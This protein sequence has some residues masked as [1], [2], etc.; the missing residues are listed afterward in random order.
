MNVFLALRWK[1]MLKFYY[2]YT[3]YCRL[4]KMTESG[5]ISRIWK[6]W[7][8]DAK[9][10]C[11]DQGASGLGLVNLFTAWLILAGLAILALCIALIEYYVWKKWGHKEEVKKADDEEQNLKDSWLSNNSS[12]LLKKNEPHTKSA[13][14]KEW[15]ELAFG[16][17]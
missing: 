10:D 7:K 11:F 3:L 15:F 4:S 5:Q 2:M 8:A 16:S 1:S 12:K 6:R 9:E 14:A 13:L 17:N